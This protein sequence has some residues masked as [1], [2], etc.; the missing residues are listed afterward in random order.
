MKHGPASPSILLRKGGVMSSASVK[1]FLSLTHRPEQSKLTNPHYGISQSTTAEAKTQ[2]N[3]HS[4]LV[5][6]DADRV[7]ELIDCWHATALPMFR[8]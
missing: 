1:L 4:Y 7:R 2:S 8:A 3:V 6:V 5:E